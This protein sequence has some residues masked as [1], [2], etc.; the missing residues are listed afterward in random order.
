[1]PI[2]GKAFCYL[3][4]TH[5]DVMIFMPG[6]VCGMFVVK[7]IHVLAVPHTKQRKFSV[8]YIPF[9]VTGSLEK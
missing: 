5:K 2:C 1:M 6:E 9:L 8:L 7:A 3:T 4:G